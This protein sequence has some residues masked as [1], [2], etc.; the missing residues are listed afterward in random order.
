MNLDEKLEDHPG[1]TCPITLKRFK[2][3]VY[4]SDGHTYEKD[5]LEKWIRTGGKS[6]LTRESMSIIG[7]NRA[8]KSLIDALTSSP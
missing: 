2:H 5:Y 7:P 8:M 1:L 6:P 3:P 4:A